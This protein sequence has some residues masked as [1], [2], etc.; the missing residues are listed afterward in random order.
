MKKILFGIICFLLFGCVDK[1]VLEIKPI[2]DGFTSEL[3]AEIQ[4][5]NKDSEHYTYLKN[6]N[7]LCVNELYTDEVDKTYEIDLETKEI[8]EVSNISDNAEDYKEKDPIIFNQDFKIYI[9]F[10]NFGTGYTRIYYQE[11]EGIKTK[12]IEHTTNSSDN[13]RSTFDFSTYSDGVNFYFLVKEND[14]LSIK[15]VIKGG[16]DEIDQILIHDKGYELENVDVISDVIHLR[17]RNEDSIRFLCGDEEYVLKMNDNGKKLIE[18]QMNGIQPQLLVYQKD[19]M[20]ELHLKDEVYDLGYNAEY[21][22]REEYILSTAWKD[23]FTEKET[24][25]IDRKTQKRYLLSETVNLVNTSS[26]AQ[27]VYLSR[28]LN[29]KESP[30]KILRIN[31]M[32]ITSIELPFTIDFELRYSLGEH[33]MIFEYQNDKILQYYLVKF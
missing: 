17:Y 10:I 20:T 19:G 26:I 27:N 9:E 18:Y 2:Q 7:K 6:I 25:Y 1:N 32:D 14:Y 16:L 4:L 3:L 12:L 22:I 15:K 13:N 33:T 23:G 30:Y 29:N 31:K 28:D 8:I 21:E 11:I 5:Y 24:I